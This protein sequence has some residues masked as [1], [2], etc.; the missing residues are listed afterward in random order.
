MA[1]HMN[2]NEMSQSEKSCATAVAWWNKSVNRGNSVNQ[3]FDEINFDGSRPDLA[4]AEAVYPTMVALYETQV[5][6]RVPNKDA[7]AQT[8]IVA[9]IEY[10]VG[11]VG[12]Y[13]ANGWV[14][15]IEMMAG[16]I[17]LDNAVDVEQANL[18]SICN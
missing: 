7:P 16:G 1:R 10:T 2:F 6:V 15:E 14:D 8:A 5:A 4:T 3:L 9:N 11:Y 18:K 17:D 12:T 13:T